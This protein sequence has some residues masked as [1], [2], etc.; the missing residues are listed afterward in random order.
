MIKGTDGTYKDKS[1][2]GSSSLLWLLSTLLG[3]E[4]LADLTL[5]VLKHLAMLGTPTKSSKL[6]YDYFPLQLKKNNIETK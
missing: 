6:Q 2:L 1:K 5:Q 4:N 3:F